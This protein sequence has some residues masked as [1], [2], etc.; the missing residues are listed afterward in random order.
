MLAPP[1]PPLVEAATAT[2][3]KSTGEGKGVSGRE[4]LRVGYLSRRFERYPGTQLMLRLFSKHDRSKVVI[5]AYAFGAD[6]SSDERA[7]IAKHADKFVDI[8]MLDP[9]AACELIRDDQIHVLVDYDGIHRA[10]N[11]HST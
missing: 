5:H 11:I 3:E 4:R 10:H 1:S 9:K 7:T 8:S 6:D 2:E